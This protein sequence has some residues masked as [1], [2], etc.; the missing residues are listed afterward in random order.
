M[1]VP[2]KKVFSGMDFCCQIAPKTYQGKGAF[3]GQRKFLGKGRKQVPFLTF[4]TPAANNE[5]SVWVYLGEDQ[6]PRMNFKGYEIDVAGNRRLIVHNACKF[7]L[8]VL[9][10]NGWGL[11]VFPI[12][13][14]RAGATVEL[15]LEYKDMNIKDVYDDEFLVRQFARPPEKPA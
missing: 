1:K 4:Q 7:D 12:N 3:V 11:V 14:S 10:N 2:C 8:Q 13:A 5:C 15:E 6:R 9:D